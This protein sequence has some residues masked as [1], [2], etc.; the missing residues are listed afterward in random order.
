MRKTL[1]LFLLAAFSSMQL[2]SQSIGGVV[3]NAEN[4]HPVSS[5][6]IVVK[7][8]TVGT[9]TDRDGK[10]QL[11]TKNIG[12]AVVQVSCVGFE[13]QELDF[14]TIDSGNSLEIQLRPVSILLNKS[15]VVTAS[16]KQLLSFHTPDAVSVL[17]SEELKHNAPRS[18][19]EALIGTAGVWMQK[20]NHGGGS[21]FVRG[22]TGNQTLLLIDGIRLNNATFRY[23]PN[24]YF[25]T[26][27]IFSVEQVEVIR[28]KGSVLY[29]SDA[30]GGVI[31]VIT[32]SPEYTPEI[33]LGG[34][35]K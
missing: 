26:I 11:E 22:L 17:T 21:P 31:N 8:S 20:T 28:G 25:N 30:L 3:I 10:F 4:N 18:M 29:G 34:G 5:A 16:R 7:N 35:Q 27:D 6:N 13:T 23:G 9:V 1:Y 2:F 32:Q 14:K 12:S 24:Q 19:A 33:A 15:I